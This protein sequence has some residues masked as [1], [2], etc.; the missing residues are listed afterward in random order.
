M[1]HRCLVATIYSYF[2]QYPFFFWVFYLF[3]LSEYFIYLKAF[4]LAHNSYTGVSLWHFHICTPIWLI[5]SSIL[6]LPLPLLKMTPTVFHQLFFFYGRIIT[7]VGTIN[8]FT[9]AGEH[10]VTPQI[11]M[12]D[13]GFNINYSTQNPP[14]QNYIK[15]FFITTY[16]LIASTWQKKHYLEDNCNPTIT[17][18]SNGKHSSRNRMDSLLWARGRGDIHGK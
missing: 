17:I 8:N 7:A 15:I 2:I 11:I 14:S 10:Q 13:L 16:L 5:P 1:S 4:W 12:Y 6:P 3:I 18:W 9:L